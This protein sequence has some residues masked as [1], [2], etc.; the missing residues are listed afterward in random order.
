VAISSFFHD[1]FVLHRHGGVK[2][3][4]VQG[5]RPSFEVHVQKT[6]AHL[7]LFIMQL[8]RDVGSVLSFAGLLDIKQV[9]LPVRRKGDK[10]NRTLR[11]HRL[12][13]VAPLCHEP[14]RSNQF[15]LGSIPD[16]VINSH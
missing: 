11:H 16:P 7:P 14:G 13:D 8:A 3:M 6:Y 9:H 10:V 15:S 5:A 2:L 1:G 12:I 4:R